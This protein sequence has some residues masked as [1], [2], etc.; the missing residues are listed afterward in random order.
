M[1]ERDDSSLFLITDDTHRPQ[2]L[3]SHTSGACLAQSEEIDPGQTTR[4]E[5]GVVRGRVVLLLRSTE[6][7]PLFYRFVRTPVMPQG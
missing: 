7:K 2:G 6:T 3:E 1:L 5:L 4:R